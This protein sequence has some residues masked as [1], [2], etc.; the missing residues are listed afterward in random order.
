[1]TFKYYDQDGTAY[2]SWDSDDEDLGYSTPKAID[3][4]LELA[5]KSNSLW[6]KTMVRLPVYREK[7]K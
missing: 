2:D 1:L 7:K 5:E 6:F 3:I 4:N